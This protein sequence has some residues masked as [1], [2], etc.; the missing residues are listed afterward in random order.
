MNTAAS[1]MNAQQMC[2]D[3]VANNLANANTSGFKTS[4]MNFQDLIYQN[5]TMAGA[6]TSDTTQIP[7]GM[8]VGLGTKATDTMKLFTQGTLQQT[9]NPLNMAIE[10]EG[11]FQVTL[12][13]GTLGYTRDGSFK[14]D[15]EGNIVNSDGYKLEPNIAIPTD[16]TSLSIGQDGTISVLQGGAT[17]PQEVGKITLVKFSNPAGLVAVGRSI[18]KESPASGSPVVGTPG[19]DGIGTILSGFLEMSNVDVVKEMV[20]MIRAQRAYQIN[21]RVIRGVDEMLGTVADIKR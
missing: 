9:D 19:T 12:P 4:R 21:S 6:P 13:D 17:E 14:I 18:F 10:G 1:G 8:Q 3:V 20:E 5:M 2:I 15:G 16:A 11:F 7:A